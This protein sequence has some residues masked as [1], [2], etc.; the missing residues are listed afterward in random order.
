MIVIRLNPVIAVLGPV[1]IR[2]GGVLAVLGVAAAVLV[3]L[4]GARRRGLETA[5]LWD[6][7]A[8]ALPFGLVGARLAHVLSDWSYYATHPA[9]VWQLPLGGLSIWGALALGGLAAWVGL[10]H[11]GADVRRGVADA[12]APALALGIAVGRIGS[13]L[14]GAG[15]GVRT[16]LPWGTMYTSNQALVPDF[17]VARHPAQVYDGLAALAALVVVVLVARWHRPGLGFWAFLLVYGAARLALAPLRLDPSFAFGL[18]LDVLI[19]SAGILLAAVGATRAIRRTQ[20]R[21]APV[22]NPVAQ[23]T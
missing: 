19:A 8:L 6:A 20:R 14:D 21:T 3:A 22:Q 5:A 17:G 1:A 13:F 9:E 11:A 18:Q 15:Q 12:A 7:V 4:W 23:W 16:S 10:R 2:W